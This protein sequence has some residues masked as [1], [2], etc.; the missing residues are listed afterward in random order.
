MSKG[1]FGGRLRSAGGF[2]W[3]HPA[4][5]RRGLQAGP[6]LAAR[7]LAI[8]PFFCLLGAAFFGQTLEVTSGEDEHSLR[9]GQPIKKADISPVEFIRIT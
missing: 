8:G 5:L 9:L 3:Q 4:L 2:A 1:H 7:S 6:R